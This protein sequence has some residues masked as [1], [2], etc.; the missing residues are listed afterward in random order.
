MAIRTLRRAAA[1]LHL[2]LA[3]AIVAGVCLQVYLIG[4]YMFGAFDALETHRSAGFTVHGLEVLI[5]V[6]ALVAWLPR[7]DVVLSL[8]VAV[9]GTVQIALAS[10]SGPWVAALHPLGALVVLA[11]AA[12]LA[13]RGSRRWAW[14][15]AA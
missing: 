9:A 5:L 10:T 3:V 11:L 12:V 13:H 8:V 7:G 2:L 14:R 15:S 6:V 1:R 4:A